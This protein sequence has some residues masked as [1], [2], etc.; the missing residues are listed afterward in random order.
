[1]AQQGIG[2]RGCALAANKVLRD[3][4]KFDRAQAPLDSQATA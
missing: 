2:C 1:L 3:Y 4:G